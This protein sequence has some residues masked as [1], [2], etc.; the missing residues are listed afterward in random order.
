MTDRYIGIENE[1][2][3]FY[4]GLMN[5]KGLSF[6]KRHFRSLKKKFKDV[7]KISPTAIR[8]DTGHG[9][10]IDGDEI[11]ILTPPIAIN[12]GFSSRLTDMLVLGRNKVLESSPTHYFTGYSMHWNFSA[13]SNTGCTDYFQPLSVPF[14]MFTLTPMSIGIAMRTCKLNEGRLE[15]LGDSINN[16]EQINAA[17]LLFGSYDIAKSSDCEKF[18]YPRSSLNIKGL[19]L[20]NGRHDSIKIDINHRQEEVSVQHYLEQFYKWLNPVVKQLGTKEEIDNLEAFIFQ[21]KQLEF[22]KFK[23]Y[24]HLMNHHVKGNRGIYKPFKLNKNL[25]TN[26]QPG[27]D[28]DVPLEG[29]LLGKLFTGAPNLIHP[30]SN[31]GELRFNG[32]GVV[33]GVKEI[34][35]YAGGLFSPSLKIGDSITID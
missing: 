21:D 5:S 8:T 23:Y 15:L 30:L 32:G 29:R 19:C 20:P 28:R 31:W 35:E 1:L 9:F 27:K 2:I 33:R 14:Y 10:Y 22:D 16:E 25:G 18:M 34:Y 12:K 24:A 17:A 11:E 7:Y 13:D 4:D 26:L 6:Q 3:M